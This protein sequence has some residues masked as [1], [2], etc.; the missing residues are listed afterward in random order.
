MNIDWEASDDKDAAYSKAVM[1]IFK[2]H[3]N[4]KRILLYYVFNF[5]VCHV[6]DV[7]I[8][9]GSLSSSFG[10]ANTRVS[11]N[12]QNTLFMSPF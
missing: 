12:F 1:G 7:Y 5:N 4:E 2:K 8:K 11:E 9:F 10:M 3:K 6:L